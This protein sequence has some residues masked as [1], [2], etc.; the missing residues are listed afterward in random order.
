M[1]VYYRTTQGMHTRFKGLDRQGLIQHL[2]Q[3]TPVQR[4]QARLRGRGWI[5]EI[6]SDEHHRAHAKRTTIE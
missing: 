6:W 4:P 2:M 1:G 3:A 5:S